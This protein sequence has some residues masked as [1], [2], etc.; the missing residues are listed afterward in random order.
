MVL[1]PA[2]IMGWH[3]GSQAASMWTAAI[4][5]G[6]Y[7]NEAVNWKRDYWLKSSALCWGK[8]LR[9]PSW[10]L[11]GFWL[12]Y[13]HWM[14]F[15]EVLKSG[16]T[17]L[18]LLWNYSEAALRILGL[19]LLAVLLHGMRFERILKSGRIALKLL[20]NCLE[21]A[22]SISFGIRTILLHWMR[23]YGVLESGRTP[24]NLLWNCSETVLKLLRNCSE[25]NG[26]VSLGI[27]TIS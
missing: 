16:R 11:L 26:S 25:E 24:L 18:K 23:F 14:R 2:G 21:V 3:H 6:L 9:L 19:S 12:F 4:L 8:V 7:G 13:L 5:D 22:R 10:S 20:R 17:A 1:L 27:W 15:Y